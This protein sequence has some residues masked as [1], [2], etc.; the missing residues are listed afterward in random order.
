M[1][2]I[3]TLMAPCSERAMLRCLDPLGGFPADTTYHVG[4]GEGLGSTLH[5]FGG[6]HGRGQ[7]LHDPGVQRRRAV[8]DDEVVVVVGGIVR[9]AGVR[10]RGERRCHGGLREGERAEFGYGAAISTTVVA[11]AVARCNLEDCQILPGRHLASLRKRTSTV[12]SGRERRLGLCETG[13][14]VGRRRQ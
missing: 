4:M 3:L 9:G 1:D 6:V 10:S 11:G 7:R 5:G 14:I 12:A 8:G 2:L 13:Q